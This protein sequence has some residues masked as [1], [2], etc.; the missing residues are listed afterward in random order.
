MALSGALRCKHRL[1]G[2]VALSSWLAEGKDS[3]DMV[4]STTKVG[5]PALL[6]HGNADVFIPPKLGRLAKD[7][8]NSLGMQTAFKGYDMMGHA[9]CPRELVDVHKFMLQVIQRPATQASPLV[10]VAAVMCAA[11]DGFSSFW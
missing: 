3:T 4:V 9:F 1:A 11:L 10:I 7:Y 2:V 5:M 6:C 8:L